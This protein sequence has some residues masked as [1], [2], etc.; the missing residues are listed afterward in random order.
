MRVTLLNY[1]LP[2][3]VDRLSPFK[4]YQFLLTNTTDSDV[5]KFLRMLTFRS[6]EDIETLQAQM[7]TS[8]YKPNTAQ[9]IL[10]QEVTRFVHGAEGLRQAE[11]ATQVIIVKCVHEH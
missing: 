6:L 11:A 2:C 5:I 3:L 4:F 7:G 9:K 1:R 10:A 8:E